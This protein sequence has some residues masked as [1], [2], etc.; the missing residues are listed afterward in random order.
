MDFDNYV[1]TN[2][3]VLKNVQNQDFGRTST[4]IASEVS[5]PQ[6]EPEQKPETSMDKVQ[7]PSLE[8]T[9]QI[10]PLEEEDSIFIEIPKPRAKK[11]VN[12][13]IQEP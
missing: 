4:P 2:D 10:P 9:A 7:K 5:T 6:K 3:A 13:E 1:K 8:S 11:T 12:V